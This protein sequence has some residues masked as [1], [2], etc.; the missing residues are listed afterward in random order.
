[1]TPDGFALGHPGRVAVDDAAVRGPFGRVE[2]AGTLA[3]KGRVDVGDGEVVA[4]GRLEAPALRVRPGEDDA[5]PGVDLDGLDWNGRIAQVEAE[6]ADD[7]TARGDLALARLRVA[8]VG[9]PFAWVDA[10][11]IALTGVDVAYPGAQALQAARVERLR[12][13]LPDDGEPTVAAGPLV[14]TVLT[15]DADGALALGEVTADALELRL[16]REP[17]GMAY[18]GAV[19]DE[20]PATDMDGA[21]AEPASEA[22][23]GW[24]LGRFA[25]GPGSR[26]LFE[27]RSVEPPFRLDVAL[28]RLELDGLAGGPGAEPG[29]L[30]LTARVGEYTRLELDGPLRPDPDALLVE[31]DGR[32]QE[33]Q[34]PQLTPYTRAHLGH[35]LNSGQL[36]AELAFRI[37]GRTLGGEQ[38]LTIDGLELEAVPSPE[39]EAFEKQLGMPLDA[40]LGLLQDKKGNVRLKLP[41]GGSLDDPEFDLGDA[42]G[43]AVA[44]ASQSAILGILKL[45]LQPY[46]AILAAAELA[47]DIASS[48]RLDPLPFAAGSDVPGDDAG[49]YL[50]RI[51]ALLEARPALKLRLCGQAAEADRAA[52]QAATPAAAPS[53]APGK[54]AAPAADTGKTPPAAPTPA[55]DDA[56]LEA[57]ARARAETVKRQLVA[58]GVPSERLLVCLPRVDPDPE[59]APRLDMLL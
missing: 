14:A 13:L 35:R 44:K 46:G 15:R 18:L 57:L 9:A 38:Q 2:N 43:Q 3:W 32:L 36:N 22:G 20:A 21:F 58:A 5:F 12:A 6:G 26:L 53:P 41:L 48:V 50:E 45:T 1:V 42:I 40:A 30:G 54:G 59:A 51:V 55:V 28:E 7:V 23:P 19:A 29:R 52:L 47:G 11:G 16:V 56:R 33:F 39:L 8:D 27:D 17:D 10:D 25:T 24:S 34:M 31:L 49:A 37:D 4:E